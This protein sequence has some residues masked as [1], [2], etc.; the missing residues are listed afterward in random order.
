MM[1]YHFVQVQH[2][3]SILPQEHLQGATNDVGS[4]FSVGDTALVVLISIEQ[5]N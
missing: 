2:C 4:P 1:K 5:D 3:I